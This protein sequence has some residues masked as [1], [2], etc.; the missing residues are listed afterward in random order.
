MDETLNSIDAKIA[1]AQDAVV[2]EKG[3]YDS[4]LAALEDL[5]AKNRAIEEGAAGGF[6]QKRQVLC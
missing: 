2:R 6:R 5:M 4:A 3:R 1:K